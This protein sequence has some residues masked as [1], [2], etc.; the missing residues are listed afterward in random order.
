MHGFGQVKCIQYNARTAVHPD[1]LGHH[2]GFR[3]ATSGMPGVYG[4]GLLLQ[5]PFSAIGDNY[6]FNLLT[7]PGDRLGKP[8][9]SEQF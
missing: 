4:P 3:V 7:G 8:V 5:L 2:S 9:L 6:R 1:L